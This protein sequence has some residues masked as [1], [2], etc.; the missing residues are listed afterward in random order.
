MDW[1]TF[2][3]WLGRHLEQSLFRPATRGQPVTLMGLAQTQWQCFDALIIAGAEQHYLPGSHHSSPFFN[4][5]VRQELGLSNRTQHIA[6]R[7]YHFRR[8]LES[9]PQIVITAC[10]E[11]DGE[12]IAISPWLER[13][14]AFHEIAWDNRLHNSSLER[15]SQSANAQINGDPHSPLPTPPAPARAHLPTDRL[16]QRFSASDYQVLMD[17]PYQ[18][19][20]ARSLSLSAPEEVRLALSK[21][22][23]GSRIHQCLDALHTDRPDLPGPFQHPFDA[24]HRQAAID[25]LTTISNAVFARDLQDHF[26]HQGWLQK[27]QAQI[28]AYIDWEIARHQHWQVSRTELACENATPAGIGLKGRIDRLDGNG[29]EYAVVDYKTG[30]VPKMDEVESG[31]KVQLPFYCLL[32]EKALPVTEVSYLALDPVSNKQKPLEGES[33][34]SLATA[35]QQRLD[36]IAAEMVQGQALP[37]WG[38]HDACR[39]CDMNRLCRRAVWQDEIKEV[40]G[41]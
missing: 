2:R 14:L 6:E 17:C 7:F 41:E 31:E 20:A 3:T 38:D 33:L 1:S 28:P 30:A 4:E 39:Y 15:L 32:T 34:Q 13:L 36:T 35:I 37:A 10:Q 25:L 29:N 23:Y 21:A 18:Y 5:G 11:Q 26:S 9:A 19:F 27:W 22:D 12:P 16:P 40:S 8:L 24:E